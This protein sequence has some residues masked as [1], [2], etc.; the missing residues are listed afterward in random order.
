MVLLSNQSFAQKYIG[1]DND[2]K[3]IL[4]KI[5]SFSYYYVNGKYKKLANCYTT[6]G[7]IFPNQS[8]IITGIENIEKRWTLPDSIKIVKHAVFP[9][10]IKIIDNHAYDYGYYEGETLL[11]NGNITP[12]KGKYVIIWRK[13]NNDWKIYLDIWNRVKD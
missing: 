4:N 5:D 11:A 2:I 1:D 13:E 12:W 7:K 9:S 8:V 10:E 3:I 6:D